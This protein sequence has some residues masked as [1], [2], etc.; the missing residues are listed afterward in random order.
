MKD[1][2]NRNPEQRLSIPDEPTRK[3]FND[4]CK[5]LQHQ[6]DEIDHLAFH[7]SD[8][9]LP[10]QDERGAVGLTSAGKEVGHE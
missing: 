5:K 6:R 1:K 7:A 3:D 9:D 2:L 10:D 4:S 8:S